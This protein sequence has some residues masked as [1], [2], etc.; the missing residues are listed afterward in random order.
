M[1]PEDAV[2]PSEV[3][4]EPVAQCLQGMLYSPV[5]FNGAPDAQCLQGMPYSPAK[6]TGA[7]DAQFYRGSECLKHPASWY[8]VYYILKSLK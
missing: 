4:G 2:F 5:K 6:F 7:P 8:A 1:F 3:I